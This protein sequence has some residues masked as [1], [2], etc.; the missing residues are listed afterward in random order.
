MDARAAD[1]DTYRAL[2]IGGK[3]GNRL[4]TAVARALPAAQISVVPDLSSAVGCDADPPPDMVLVWTTEL[5]PD[6]SASVEMLVRRLPGAAIL[7]AETESCPADLRK[8]L[9][10]GVQ[11][12][13]MAPESGDN[14]DDDRFQEVVSRALYRSAFVRRLR[15]ES[16]TDA[17][18]GLMNRRGWLR[19]AEAALHACRRSNA[20]CLVFMWDVDNLKAINDTLGHDAG[21]AVLRRFAEALR[22]ALRASDSVARWG[23]DEFVALTPGASAQQ[24]DRI[25]RRVMEEFHALPTAEPRNPGVSFGSAQWT[26]SSELTI[27]D[28]LSIA[29]RCLYANKAEA[30]R[31]SRAHGKTYLQGVNAKHD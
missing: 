18:T 15:A 3:P 21:D 12:V 17:L 22:G 6:V 28:L 10:A 31:H 11:D 7:V 16:E 4:M 27:A 23:G 19:A 26:P 30:G 9:E 20:P 2:V 8:L 1:P 14:P 5:L 13:V 25:H 29:D 24:A